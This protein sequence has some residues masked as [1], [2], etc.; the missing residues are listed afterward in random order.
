MES[1]NIFRISVNS[2]KIVGK[3]WG[4]QPKTMTWPFQ[5]LT[6]VKKIKKIYF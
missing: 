2:K 6:D 4:G 1:H 5:P 3:K